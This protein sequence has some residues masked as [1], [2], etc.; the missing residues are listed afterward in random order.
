MPK[1]ET[2]FAPTLFL[3]CMLRPMMCRSWFSTLTLAMWLGVS[4]P[5]LAQTAVP[6]VPAPLTQ[7]GTGVGV[8]N[9]RLTLPWQRRGDRIGIADIPLMQTL[10]LDLQDGIAPERQVVH[11]FSEEAATLPVWYDGGYRYLDITDW[12]S[13]RGWQLTPTAN[14]LE[15][16]LPQGQVLVGRRGRQAWGDRLVLEVDRPLGWVLAE[17]ADRFSLTL[18]GTPGPGFTAQEVQGNG[19]LLRQVQVGIQGG[20][21]VIQGQVPAQARVRVWSL[22]NPPRVVVDVRQDV[23]PRD[24]VWA[25]GVRWQTRMV[26]VGNRAFPVHLLRLRLGQPQLALRAIWGNQPSVPGITPLVTLASR[27]GAIAAINAGFFNRN[28]Q[29]PLGA[30]RRDGRWISGPI[31][32]R[33]AIAWNDQGRV[34]LDRLFLIHTLTTAQGRRF[35]ITQINSGFVQAGVGLYTPEWGGGY[36]PI[37]DGETVVAVN[38]DQ[39]TGQ[40]P[41]GAA[42]SRTIPIPVGG[43]LLAVRA[44]SE[45]AQ[46]LAPGTAVTLTPEVR[47]GAF[48]ELPH[49][50]SGGPLLVKDQRIVVDPRGEGFSQAFAQEAAPRSAIATTAHGELLLVAIQNSPGG[51]GPT[52]GEAAQVMV[53]LGAIDALNLDGGSSTSL[54]LG[55]TLINRHPQTVGRIHNALGVFLQP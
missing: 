31:L 3:P 12:A 55:G 22:T 40:T 25:P 4:A 32:N 7:G 6:P 44:F 35:P 37:L 20:Q 9:Q 53:Q 33:G 18:Q 24:L 38:G 42:G 8:G 30:I 10:G 15:V 2:A 23:T 19:G 14:G 34:A 50:V 1:S 11:W 21:V 36:Q 26:A 49:G 54:Y 39:V 16:R 51:R 47:P 17:Q 5:V 43:Y 52:L 41:G 48:G 46:A 27:T 29:L 13:Q 28:N 45:A